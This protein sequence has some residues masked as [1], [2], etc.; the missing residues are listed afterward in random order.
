VVTT[1]RDFQFNS[2]SFGYLF[3]LAKLLP[4]LELNEEKEGLLDFEAL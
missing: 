2:N 3:I 1:P 4:E